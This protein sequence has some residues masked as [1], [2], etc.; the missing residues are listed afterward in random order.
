M[1]SV[2]L[3]IYSQKDPKSL[4]HGSQ[5]HNNDSVEIPQTIKTEAMT[6]FQSNNRRS[7][8]IELYIFVLEYRC[9]ISKGLQH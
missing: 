5:A 8:V 1:K 4:A 7:S 3:I 2:V 9:A 6:Q